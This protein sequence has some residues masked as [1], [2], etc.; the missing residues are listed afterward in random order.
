MPKQSTNFRMLEMIFG[1]FLF[2]V[3]LSSAKSVESKLFPVISGFNITQIT[4]LDNGI[5]IRGMMNKKRSCKPNGM[6]VY[7]KTSTSTTNMPVDYMIEENAPENRAAIHQ[8]WGPWVIFIP[9]KYDS[10]D[11][12]LFT[13]HSCHVFYDTPTNIHNF[14]IARDNNSELYI[15]ETK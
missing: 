1:V 2:V 5:E 14:S 12:K 10:A 6:S 8:S 9:E 4:E 15:T 13:S 11:I 3:L 7:V